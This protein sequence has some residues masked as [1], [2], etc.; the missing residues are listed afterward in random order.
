M[1]ERSDKFIVAITA[2]AA[3]AASWLA[4][5]AIISGV[6]FLHEKYKDMSTRSK[7]AV[8]ASM[9]VMAGIP[10][11]GYLAHEFSKYLAAKSA[12]TEFSAIEKKILGDAPVDET[13]NSCIKGRAAEAFS[14]A[15]NP[16]Y[17]AILDRPKLSEVS[18]VNFSYEFTFRKSASN[19]LYMLSGK[20]DAQT[21]NAKYLAGYLE[22]FVWLKPYTPN[23]KE[24]P[25]GSNVYPEFKP[26]T[27]AKK[28][29]Y[30]VC[31]N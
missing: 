7:M 23:M 29:S 21:K 25:L 28:E 26:V 13:V 15:T 22:H 30:S 11:S 8:G 1:S 4:S 10:T 6:K 31:I 9:F 16:G 27:C 20:E 19:C 2:V 3:I 18:N 14:T 12:Y 24:S 5:V 17:F